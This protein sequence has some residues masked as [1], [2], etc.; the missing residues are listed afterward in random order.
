[1]QDIGT[2]AMKR[3]TQNAFCF[4]ISLLLFSDLKAQQSFFKTS[5]FAAQA[6][7]G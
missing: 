1:L 7:Y 4:F 6:H 3:C 2:I 5:S